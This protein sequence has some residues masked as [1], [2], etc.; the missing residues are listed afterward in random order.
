MNSKTPKIDFD[1]DSIKVINADGSS[2]S[3]KWSELTAVFILTTDQG[4]FTDDVF[5]LLIDS[6]HPSGIVV[7]QGTIGDRNLFIAL[8]ERLPGFDNEKVIE[9]MSST[10]NTSFLIWDQFKLR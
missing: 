9:A 1:D 7:P 3:I 10:E 5:F 4:P 2:E 8:Q 6:E